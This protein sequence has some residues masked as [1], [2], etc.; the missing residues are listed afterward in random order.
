MPKA[1]AAS[2][3]A[4]CGLAQLRRFIS[5]KMP[6]A[7]ARSR[8]RTWARAS[9][10][11]TSRAVRVTRASPI[12]QSPARPMSRKSTDRCMV[13][14]VGARGPAG[15]GSQEAVQEC[16]DHASMD[17]AKTVAMTSERIEGLPGAIGDRGIVEVR[18]VVRGERSPPGLKQIARRRLRNRLA[19]HRWNIRA[20]TTSPGSAPISAARPPRNL[21][22]ASD[23][24]A[25]GDRRLVH[26]HGIARDRNDTSVRRDEHHVQ[27]D[28][29][30][31]HPER[32]RLGLMKVEQHALIGAQALAEHEAVL[33]RGVGVGNLHRE[34]SDPFGRGD[35]Q[36]LGAKTAV[37]RGGGHQSEGH[38][39]ERQASQQGRQTTIASA[40]QIADA[41]VRTLRCRRRRPSLANRRF[42]QVCSN[43][44]SATTR[45]LGPLAKR[46]RT[47]SP[48][49]RSSTP[50]RR[51]TSMWMK[52]SPSAPSRTTN[53]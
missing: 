22:H 10:K 48:G 13:T 39:S 52:M 31:L 7:R 16:R 41:H 49:W 37:G 38:Q 42:P 17:E 11:A 34:V 53:P 45:P 50:P 33:A 14:G 20:V 9:T 6:E 29:G 27:R 51:R 21:E 40:G 23:R 2:R 26:R 44:I 1:G 36:R 32:N 35:R 3:K 8:S 25:R 28:Q 12:T 24:A 47:S 15:R 46:T 19:T 4:R 5:L 18:P 30:V 43:S